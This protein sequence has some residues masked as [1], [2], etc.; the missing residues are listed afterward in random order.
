M[1]KSR[2]II[3]DKEITAAQYLAEFICERIAEKEGKRL[4][5]KFWNNK[6]WN[7][8]FRLQIT[9]AN[10][11]LKDYDNNVRCIIRA[12]NTFQGKKVYSL[13][14]RYIL[15]PLIIDE[16]KKQAVIKTTSLQTEDVA[17]I[18]ISRKPFKKHNKLE[19]L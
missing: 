5:L 6:E 17:D 12:L 4:A 19:D 11:L 8:K 10:K 16:I 13:G 7:K 9:H 14:A 3:E 2:Y 1:F 15:D 18:P